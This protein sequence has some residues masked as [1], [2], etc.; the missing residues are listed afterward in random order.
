MH[1]KLHGCRQWTLSGLCSFIPDTQLDNTHPNSSARH[2]Q[3]LAA[4]ATNCDSAAQPCCRYAWIAIDDPK[5]LD[6]PHAELLLIGERAK[7]EGEVTVG[8]IVVRDFGRV[9]VHGDPPA[10]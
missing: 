8:S 1:Q 6:F 9:P 10:C 2:A 5:L 7:I 3:N 4:S